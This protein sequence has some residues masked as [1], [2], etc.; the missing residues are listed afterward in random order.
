MRNWLWIGIALGL[1]VGAARAGATT[2]LQSEWRMAS[3]E[4]TQCTGNL[5][6]RT[7]DTTAVAPSPGGGAFDAEL[8]VPEPSAGSVSQHSVVGVTPLYSGPIQI[9]LPIQTLDSIQGSGSVM[10]LVA[11]YVLPATLESQLS[12]TFTTDQDTRVSFSGELDL[13]TSSS[14]PAAGSGRVKLCSG[15]TCLFSLTF[16][17]P[18]PTAAHPGPSFVQPFSYEGTLAAGTYTFLIDAALSPANDADPAHGQ[19]A[20]W[21]LSF[22]VPEPGSAL[23]ALIGL[24]GLAARR[25]PAF[26]AAF[27]STP[28]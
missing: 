5:C 16:Q 9:S 10:S 25:Q 23:L 13:T 12:E 28:R 27:R 11:A 18:P 21:S 3:I 17:N 26:E 14:D 15:S 20:G 19:S 6:F 2:L 1:G 7:I 22:V 24:M 8:S 4:S